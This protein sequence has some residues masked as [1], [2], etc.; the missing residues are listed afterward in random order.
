MTAYHEIF[1]RPL[2]D[3]LGAAGVVRDLTVVLGVEFAP[4]TADAGVAYRGKVGETVV[5]VFPSHDLIDD[6][7]LPFDSH[8]IQIDFRDLTKDE[9]REKAVMQEAL[10]GLAYL[11]RYSLFA[12]YNTQVLIESRTVAES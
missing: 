5:E 12:T 7:G 1:L 11:A 2:R 9:E 10:D 6:S 3:D 4:I 8:P